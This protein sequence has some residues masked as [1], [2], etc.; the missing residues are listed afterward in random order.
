M[1]RRTAILIALTIWLAAEGVASQPAL[2]W[3][4]VPFVR[5]EKNACGAAVVSMLMQYWAQQQ[6]KVSGSA[7]DPATILHQL[8]SE[9]ARGIFANDLQR[10]LEEHDFRTFVFHGRWEDLTG[11]LAKGRPLIAATGEA[12][13]GGTLHYVIVA[14]VDVDQRLVMVND[15]ARRKLL[16]VHWSDF[17]HDWAATEHWTLLALP[18]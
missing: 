8:Y 10:Y 11:H 5:Q 9:K 13:R 3:L 16:K 17:E 4:D 1:V 2:L 12:G 15:P 18:R 7:A 14:G 6:D